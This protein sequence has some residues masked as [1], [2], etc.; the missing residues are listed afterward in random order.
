MS[1]KEF[2]KS[3]KAALKENLPLQ[4]E[5]LLE[6]LDKE[7]PISIRLNPFKNNPDT[8]YLQ[9]VPWTENAFYLSK[10]PAFY[11]DPFYHSGGYYVQEA[12]SM[13]VE[14]ILNKLQFKNK[15]LLALDLCAAPG[16]KSTIL[17][18]F[19]EDK[20]I[21]VSNEIVWKR[22]IILQENLERWG[23]SNTIIT[24]N[25]SGDFRAINRAFDFILVDAPCSGEGMFR[26]DPRVIQEW[27]PANVASC[28]KRQSAILED[29][30]G[31]LKNEGFL[32]YS[33]C[34]YNHLENEIQI[35]DFLS[36]KDFE[37]IEIEAMEDFG[38][39]KNTYGKAIFY[40]L[41]PHKLKGEGLSICI[42]KKKS[43]GGINTKPKL[44]KGVSKFSKI[45]SNPPIEFVNENSDFSYVKR[46]NEVFAIKSFIPEKL[47]AILNPLR[48]IKFGTHIGDFNRHKFVP[49]HGLALSLLLSKKISSIELDES[50]ALRVLQRD[51]S[52]LE[53]KVEYTDWLALTFKGNCL[54]LAKNLKNRIN[55][56]IPK[57][58]RIR[59]NI[60]EFL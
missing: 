30:A 45:E 46:E 1:Q 16:G 60:D 31:S 8:K 32:I 2:P 23:Q 5:N 41:F 49:S 29:I 42:M 59:K 34:T 19:L 25:N 3:F 26:K 9:K 43:S 54:A 21:L 6:A 56:H 47:L 52:H 12:S 18:T 53:S 48:I 57:T 15:E 10:R 37:C 39:V 20:G 22:N 4:A 7:S 17:S 35:N 28:A 11:A 38:V 58:F 44:K 51:A 24:H 27:S 40:R 33:T 13:I 36:Q 14:Y 55:I 50:G